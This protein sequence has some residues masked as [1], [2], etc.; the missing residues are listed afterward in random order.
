VKRAATLLALAAAAAAAAAPATAHADGPA[1]A[2]AA[3]SRFPDRAYALTLPQS[4][5]VRSDQVEVRENG[6]VVSGVAVRSPGQV[7]PDRFGVVLAIDT[8]WSMRG[9][10][11]HAAISAA[12]AFLDH[13]D[14]RQ[15]VALLTFAGDI[16]VVQPFTT[17][18]AQLGRA[19]SAVRQSGGGS[20]L[21][22]AGIEAMALIRAGHIASGS[23]VLLTDG[24][25]RGSGATQETLAGAAKA[26][27]TRIFTVG[28]RSGSTDL[29]QL[30]L[31]AATTA[32]EFSTAT[33]VRD[34]ARIYRR[35][36]SVL[37][38]QYLIQYRSTAGPHVSVRVDV[39]V[40]GLD[41]VAHAA[42]VTPALDRTVRAPF[43]RAPSERLWASRAA[44]VAASVIVAA[45]LALAIWILLRPRRGSVR[46][47]MAA[48]VSAVAPGAADRPM[49]LTGRRAVAAAKRSLSRR[50]WMASLQEKFDVGRIPIP[51]ERA[52]AWTGATTL[53]MLLA[54]PLVIGP[55][56]IVLAL[57]VPVAAH[58]L[59]ERRVAKQ[60]SLFADQL[61]DNL[62][63][64][65]SAM[66]AGHSFVGALQVVVEDAPEPARE[67]LE[68]VIADERLGVPL[69]DAFATVVR[70]MRSKDLEQVALVAALQRET[71]GNTAEVIDRV[72]DA[73][74]ERMALRRLV[75]ALT[76][77]GRMSR[78]V[79]SAIP[80]VLLLLLTTINPR[81]MQ[82]LYTTAIGKTLLVVAATMV[83]AG[84]LVI[85][86]I[87]NITV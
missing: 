15:P 87:V 85:K 11:L 75:N 78:W 9:R 26:A 40:A 63:V 57:I 25:D 16:R 66:R 84:S 19:L 69:E 65:A 82:P 49:T 3:G 80:V 76:A 71:G 73:M 41:G 44:P 20:R 54:G 74:R 35:L 61:P 60:R 12:R 62:Q 14:P 43:H 7:Q 23:V 38:N 46:A 1:I 47:R 24:A 52:L 59:V 27:G 51:P 58:V 77:Q 32:G 31:L 48:Y 30:N 8:S 42:Y 37:S 72:T 10:P 29:G 86:R 81:Y 36:G 21:L 83:V 34:L 17:D 79:L 68:Q 33:S 18:A 64:I 45:L 56:G 5:A 28:L 55:A 67:E 39:R 4:M 50:G 53:L 6:R 2:A 70:R 22:D 13:R